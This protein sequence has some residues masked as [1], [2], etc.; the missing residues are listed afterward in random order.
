M[1]IAK[2]LQL[3]LHHQYYWGCARLAASGRTKALNAQI[4]SPRKA[5]STLYGVQPRISRKAKARA[6][7]SANNV[8][9]S[10][11]L[12]LTALSAK[13]VL[14]RE[15]RTKELSAKDLSRETKNEAPLSARLF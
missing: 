9:D 8:A 5:N 7:L 15:A 14:S 6:P 12:P 2:L 10:T 11:S 3:R 13:K 4:A 1:P